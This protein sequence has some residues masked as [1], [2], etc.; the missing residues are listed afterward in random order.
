MVD[1]TLRDPKISSRAI[2]DEMAL[3]SEIESAKSLEL[4]LKKANE[5][6][7][8]EAGIKATLRG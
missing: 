3:K 7:S 4:R 1:L 5:C 6:L 2:K 8:K